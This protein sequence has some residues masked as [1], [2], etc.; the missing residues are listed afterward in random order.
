ML[1]NCLVGVTSRANCRDKLQFR[2]SASWPG[3]SGLAAAGQRGAFQS[4][5]EGENPW[6]LRNYFNGRES[7]A[8]CTGCDF[9]YTG[10]PALA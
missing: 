2:S 7:A 3:V 5:P 6:G 9:N 4:F 1:L 8:Q 10:D